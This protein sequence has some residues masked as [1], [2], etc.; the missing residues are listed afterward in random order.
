MNVNAI[1]T[2][3]AK[4]LG[5]DEN[6]TTELYY[7]YYNPAFNPDNPD[8]LASRIHESTDLDETRLVLT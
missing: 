5:L 2:D 4:D 8:E 3:I 1:L 6:S 7:Y